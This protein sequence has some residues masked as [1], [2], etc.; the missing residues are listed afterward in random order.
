MIR[1][2]D[3]V[4]L[5]LG[6][7]LFYDPEPWPDILA[8]ADAA[9]WQALDAAGVHAEPREILEGYDSLFNLYNSNHRKD[10]SEPTTAGVLR[11]R[12]QRNGHVVPDETLRSALRAMYAVTQANWLLEDDAVPLLRQLKEADFRL[13]VISNAAD[14]ENTQRLIDKGGIRAYLEFIMSSAAYGRR[15][16]DPG[17][18]RAALDHFSVPAERAVM[19][20]DTYEADIV[21]A[22]GVG[23]HTIWIR[24]RGAENA[25]PDHPEADE[26]VAG[27]LEIPALIAR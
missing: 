11:D 7:T 18:F 17:I 16:P 3:L 20:G 10:L 4:I 13:G 2:I 14:D 21:G 8:R 19:V 24:R 27:L 1:P 5:D 6:N 25:E 15:K 26:V 23:M 22:K 9:L 12:L